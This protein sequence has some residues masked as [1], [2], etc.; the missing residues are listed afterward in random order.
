[1]NRKLPV[2]NPSELGLCCRYV[3]SKVNNDL[4]FAFPEDLLQVPVYPLSAHVFKK[5]D[6][7]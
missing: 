6:N 4:V 3:C 1:M 7:Y 2:E 5:A